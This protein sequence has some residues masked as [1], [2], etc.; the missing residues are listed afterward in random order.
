VVVDLSKLFGRL[1]NQGSHDI[2]IDR[3]RKH[4]DDDGVIRLILV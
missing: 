2:L 4:I 1:N 3:P